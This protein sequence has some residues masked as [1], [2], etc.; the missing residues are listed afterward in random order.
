MNDEIFAPDDQSTPPL[1]YQKTNSITKDI[2]RKHHSHDGHF[3]GQYSYG[4]NNHFHDYLNKVNL[5]N[6]ALLKMNKEW[7]STLHNKNNFLEQEVG[8]V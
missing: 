1:K 5:I 6:N 8:V 7:R 4:K 2:N 3:K